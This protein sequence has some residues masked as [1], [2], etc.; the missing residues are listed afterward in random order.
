MQ[1]DAAMVSSLSI[2]AESKQFLVEAG[3]PCNR[4]YYFPLD[5]THPTLPYIQS[6]CFNPDRIPSEY[7]H[8]RF[9][10]TR[11]L[12]TNRP[13]HYGICEEE[14][15]TVYAI[16]DDVQNEIEI[17]FVSSSVQQYAA[18][19]VHLER[20]Q[21]WQ[22]EAYATRIDVDAMEAAKRLVRTLR[23]I[24]PPACEPETPAGMET[25]LGGLI[26]HIEFTGCTG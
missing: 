4:K 1:Y 25:E 15:G 2:S 6:V 13:V 10:G 9:L 19:V 14:G 21:N 8:L 11:I 20:W 24:D 22:N 23:A 3:L 17:C 26:T 5:A 16:H 12:W 18:F 7:R